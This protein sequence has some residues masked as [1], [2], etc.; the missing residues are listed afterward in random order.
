MNNPLKNIENA[1]GKA[2]KERLQI[3]YSLIGVSLTD[4]YYNALKVEIKAK[5]QLETLQ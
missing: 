4:D 5:Q 1:Y 3:Q 2:I